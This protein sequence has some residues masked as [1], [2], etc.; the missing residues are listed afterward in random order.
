MRA[1]AIK[2]ESSVQRPDCANAQRPPSSERRP[3]TVWGVDLTPLELP[4]PPTLAELGPLRELVYEG[5]P[6]RWRVRDRFHRDPAVA[7]PDLEE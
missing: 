6:L 5:S 7:V 3:R 4:R 2:G 1:V